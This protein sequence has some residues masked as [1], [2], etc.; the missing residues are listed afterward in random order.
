MPNFYKKHIVKIKKNTVK[1]LNFWMPI[2]IF[3][4]ILIKMKD[5]ITEGYKF[6]IMEQNTLIRKLSTGKE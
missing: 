5:R 4:A 6:Y 2:H 1:M 3:I